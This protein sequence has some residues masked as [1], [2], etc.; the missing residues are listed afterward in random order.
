MYSFCI[1]KSKNFTFENKLVFV[2]HKKL[3]ESIQD[4]IYI[5]RVQS[6]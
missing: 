4:K 1:T 6:L 5:A 3:R 2:S